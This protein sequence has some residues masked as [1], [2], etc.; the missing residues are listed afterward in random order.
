MGQTYNVGGWLAN[1]GGTPNEF[2]IQ[3]NSTELLDLINLPAQA[4]TLEL[5]SF[6]GT[7]SDLITFSFQQNPAFFQ[8][9]DAFVI[10]PTPEPASLTLLGF[11]LIGLG[12]I[13]RRF[14]YF[15]LSENITA[16]APSGAAFALAAMASTRWYRLIMVP[17][18][19]AG[20]SR[21]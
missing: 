6:V 20:L 11:A 16:A 17:K 2:D 1:D 3:V 7:G 4:Y 13:R 18:I 5:T 19:A 10:T 15:G 14:G 21:R 8:F 9:D 12:A